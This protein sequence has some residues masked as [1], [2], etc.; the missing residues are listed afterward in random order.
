MSEDQS[1][2]CNSHEAPDDLSGHDVM[3]SIVNFR[4]AEHCIACLASLAAEREAM[5]GFRVTVADGGSGDGSVEALEEWIASKG[6]NDWIRVLPLSIN[7]GFGWAH[8]QVMMRALQSDNPPGFIYL[9]N[10]DTILEPGAIL[11]LRR[12][13]SRDC[14]TGCVGSQMIN[15]QGGLQPAGFRLANIRT[16]FARG[17]HTDILV[18]LFFAK[19]SLVYL[20]AGTSEIE[21]VSGASF[22]IRAAA[23]GEVGLFDTGFFLYFEEF[24][25][26]KRFRARGWKIAHE[27]FSRVHHV[28]GA[29]TKLS[30]DREVLARSARPFYWYQ[31]Q[32][33]YLYRTLG[34]T[35]ARLAGLAWFLGYVLVAWPR[36]LLS[37]NVRH[38]LVKNEGRD[39]LRAWVADERFDRRAFVPFPL[40]PIDQPPAWHA[41]Q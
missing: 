41:R 40:D 30:R 7:G 21:A 19:P 3:I 25:W 20:A 37:R 28:G 38:R 27:P 8:N 35:R 33:R 26:M 5:S 15:S 31:S 6:Y 1:Y 22:M 2:S 29:A 14:Q 32:R 13:F 17:A 24:E 34:V 39:M 12:A 18:R 23:L 11:A 10:P 36:A 4:T 9:L 16:E